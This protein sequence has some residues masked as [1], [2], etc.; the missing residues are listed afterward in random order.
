MIFILW[1]EGFFSAVVEGFVSVAVLFHDCF[2]SL[3]QV[4]Q[5]PVHWWTFHNRCQLPTK[6]NRVQYGIGNSSPL[7]SQ[8]PVFDAWTSE[9]V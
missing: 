5:W 7:H 2:V 3:P 8:E 1:L 6:R 9:T 4:L